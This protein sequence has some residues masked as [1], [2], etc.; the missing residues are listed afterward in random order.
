MTFSDLNEFCR[1]CLLPFNGSSYID[2]AL[3]EHTELKDTIKMVYNID[4]SETTLLLWLLIVWITHALWFHFNGYKYIML[5]LF[6]LWIRSKR[7][8]SIQ[9]KCVRCA[10]TF[11][12]WTRFIMC[13]LLKRK[14]VYHEYSASKISYERTSARRK[15]T[16]RNGNSPWPTPWFPATLKWSKWLKVNQFVREKWLILFC[17]FLSF[18]FCRSRSW[19]QVSTWHVFFYSL[20]THEFW[21]ADV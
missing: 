6:L 19:F 1:L 8:T 12:W 20:L 16:K 15:P 18:C 17:I 4:V 21:I 10:V 3:G 9:R 7:M 2:C 5:L 11:C 14:R 13:V